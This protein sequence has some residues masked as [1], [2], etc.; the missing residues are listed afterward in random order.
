MPQWIFEQ[1][2]RPITTIICDPA[3]GARVIIMTTANSNDGNWLSNPQHKRKVLK[4]SMS[5]RYFKVEL[6][7]NANIL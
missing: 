4:Q 7:N 5:W 3:R 1:D 2:P 6:E